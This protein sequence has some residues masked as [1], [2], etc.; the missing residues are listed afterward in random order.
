MTVTDTPRHI[1]DEMEF[2]QA[3]LAK[4]DPVPVP[5]WSYPLP[6]HVREDEDLLH[7]LTWITRAYSG[8]MGRPGAWSLDDWGEAISVASCQEATLVVNWSPFRPVTGKGG[9]VR[10][11]ETPQHAAWALDSRFFKAFGE[12][13]EEYASIMA[14]VPADMTVALVI[15]FEYFGVTDGGS[16][17][18]KLNL[19]YDAFKEVR[20]ATT[21]VWYDQHHTHATMDQVNAV[22]P[23]FS[24][25]E[26]DGLGY[27]S[28]YL[29]ADLGGHRSIVDNTWATARKL[30]ASG[31]VAA[32]SLGSCWRRTPWT[33][34][35]EAKRVWDQV[36]PC[37]LGTTW[38]LGAFIGQPRFH[39]GRSSQHWGPCDRYGHWDTIQAVH[40]YPAPFTETITGF[41]PQFV[42]FVKGM[43]DVPLEDA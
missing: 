13:L 14:L 41:G 42:A 2:V 31:L 35:G 4:L 39:E 6:E 9:Y 30:G 19:I 17:T 12:A 8:R 10:P 3:E 1:I 28:L 36:A 24:C 11:D 43:L 15:D 22:T 34:K 25:V 16:L 37:D 5:L 21:I 38:Q 23:W 32:V 20:D 18:F 29:G 33:A 7:R 40:L 27:C 26:N